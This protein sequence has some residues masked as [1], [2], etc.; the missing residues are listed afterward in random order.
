MSTA[1]IGLSA[2]TS[3]GQGLHRPE[4]VLPTPG[5]DVYVPDWHGGVA[6]V[7]HDGSTESW[8][9]KNLDFE[10]KPNGIGFLPDGR[11][12][13]ANLGDEG[14]VWTMDQG[15]HAVSFLTEID[16]RPLPPAN[17]VHVDEEERVWI[18]VSTRHVPRQAAW[19]EDVRDG[20][21]VLIDRKGARIVADGLH[22]TNEARTD[23]TGRFVYLVETFGRR[24][25]RYPITGAGLGAAELVVQMQATDWPDGFVFDREDGIW[26]TSLIS[27]RITRLD[28]QG[29]LE[30]MIAE[31]N[32]GFM[33][34]AV[35]TYR[36]NRMERAHLGPIPGT[37]FQHL[38]SIGFGGA[39]FRTG[40]LGSLHADCLY[41][42]DAPVAGLPQVWW[43]Y[44]L[45]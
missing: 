43:G 30:L 31:S 10:L 41:R 11:F 40:Y 13:I 24:L 32:A 45:P 17:F 37:R 16:G 28:R 7:R 29:R 26:I 23:P 25:I 35:E 3:F 21:L 12:L 4:C 14:G 36:G 27:N 20:F 33:D 44:P 8:L 18:T 19:R 1:A 2:I 5:G 38:T 42:F 15:G 9:A 34:Q 39:D 22:Y 6:V